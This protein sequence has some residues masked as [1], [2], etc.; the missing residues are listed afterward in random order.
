MS[1]KND[2]MISVLLVAHD[3][4]RY[5]EKVLP[6]IH[7]MLTDHYRQFEL[8]CVDNGSTDGSQET[9]LKALSALPNMRYVRL[10]RP[11][12]GEVALACALDQ[13]VGDVAV[14]F[15]PVTDD[16][17]A[18]PLLVEAATTGCIA[19][20]RRD[21][22]PTWVRSVGARIFYSVAKHALGFSLRPDE[23]NQRAYPR[24]VLSALTRIKNRRRNLRYYTTLVGFSQQLVEV[25][26]GSVSR[27]ESLNQAVWRSLDLLFSNSVVPL[28]WAAGLGLM[29]ALGNFVYLA[30]IMVVAALKD[31]V[32]EGWITQSLSTTGMFMVLFLMLAVLSEYVGRILEEVQERPLYFIELERDGAVEVGTKSLNVV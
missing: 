2:L 6:L 32:A 10:S 24:S 18:I 29:A 11:H 12:P 30:F 17:N 22:H 5:L 28:R 26:L 23:G 25:P 16:L 4:R 13:A 27:N 1:I 20:A 31:H 21:R 9:L 14:T 7:P 15:D 19:V 8:V 3:D